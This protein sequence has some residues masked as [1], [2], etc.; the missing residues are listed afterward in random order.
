MLYLLLGEN[1]YKRE[2]ELAKIFDGAIPEVVDGEKLEL[3][4]LPDLFAGQTLFALERT[5]V[6]TD[7]SANKLVWEQL[8]AWLDR[9]DDTTTLVLAETA[10]DKRTR[11]YKMLQKRAKVILCDFWKQN[12]TYEAKKW[13]DQEAKRQAITLSGALADEM[14]RRA[15]R[16][17]AS[18]GKLIIDQQRLATVLKQLAGMA[19][20]SLQHID[21]VMAPD[22]HENIFML[23]TAALD[24]DASRVRSM[25]NNL[26]VEEDGYK[27]LGLLLSQVVNLAL[28]STKG[29]RSLDQVASDTGVSVYALRPL[30]P[31]ARRL[32]QSDIQAIVSIFATVDTRAKRGAEPWSV[33]ETGLQKIALS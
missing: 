18:D 32:S 14:I 5:I 33:I 16:P 19:E 17:N 2:Q 24:G 28:L 8:E 31:Y 15:M 11:T 1:T 7:L 3:R 21:T 26:S 25:T 9:L 29:A 12:E 23:L 10:L 30:E 4:D 22:I 13:L 20:I 27:A 6:V